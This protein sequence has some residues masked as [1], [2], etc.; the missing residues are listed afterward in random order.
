MDRR[1]E[2]QRASS[3]QQAFAAQS[4][5]LGLPAE[6]VCDPDTRTI[7][8]AFA[9]FKKTVSVQ[10]AAP[11]PGAPQASAGEDSAADAAITP[12]SRAM[13]RSRRRTFG[14]AWRNYA[15]DPHMGV[16]TSWVGTVD[17]EAVAHWL[18]SDALAKAIAA[19]PP[20][21]PRRVTLQNV[22][23]VYIGFRPGGR[24]LPRRGAARQRP[25]LGRQSGR[26]ADE[27]RRRGL[28]DRRRHQGR[29]RR[30]LSP[31]SERR[32]HDGFRR[33]SGRRPAR[34]RRRLPA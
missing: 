8:V 2:D 15:T 34:S 7:G 1:K 32:F 22:Q 4:E 3:L 25:G 31:S 6:S 18:K 17:D 27:R 12:C 23:I 28:A 5:E 33:G 19:F 10:M 14:A 24:D 21:S 13:S 16:G 30:G 29:P 26:G 9:A 11:A 20:H